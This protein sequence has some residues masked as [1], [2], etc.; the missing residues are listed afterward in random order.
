[1]TTQFDAEDPSSRNDSIH[2]KSTHDASTNRMSRRQALSCL[3]VWSGSAVIWS[4]A[5][6]VPRAL[7]MAN[8]PVAKKAA[9]N[10]FSFAQISDTHVG[11]HK[12]AN[13]DVI[14]TLRRAIADINSVSPT[15]VAHTGDITHL[16]KPEE[17]DL[18][19][20]VLQELKVDRIHYVPGEHDTLSNGLGGYLQRYGTAGNDAAYY[21]F[22][23]HGVH[24]VALV[25]V[26]DF[27]AGSLASL[28]DAQLAWLKKDLAGISSSTPIV[29][30]AHIP[31]WTVYEPWG[32]GTSDAM[33]A[34]SYL[35]RFGSV[36]VLN[37]HIHQ[38][39]QKVEGNVA[40]HTAMSTAFPQPQPQPGTT[41]E[42]GPL[43]VPAGEL[44]K[45][46]GTRQIIVVRGKHPL[47]T[48]DTPIERAA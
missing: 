9:K 35:K 21:S 5:G 44:G 3:G 40:F 48:I 12:E 6:G 23:D 32:W 4:L 33:Q 39:M 11:F 25:N 1:M 14:A 38:V 20:Q 19:A 13:P 42:P 22:N 28:G 47:A 18:A 34:M 26:V 31:L 37:G 8:D 45:V 10:S 15:F 24:F 30:L 36:T 41:A 17:F 7:G 43:K 46:L 27:K 2:D 16:S 29:V